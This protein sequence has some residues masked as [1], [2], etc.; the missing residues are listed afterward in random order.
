M[1]DT[2]SPPQFAEGDAAFRARGDKAQA[3]RAYELYKKA[4]TENP[5]DA[6]AGW[7]YAMICYF[8]GIKHT[9]TD[10]QRREIY[11][12]GRD[13][14]LEALK[15]NDQC[16]ACYFWTAIDMA[17]YG[18]ATGPFKMF[19][20]LGTIKEYLEKGLRI[21]PAYA[22]GGAYRLLGQIDE[23]LPGFLGGSVERAALHYEKAIATVPDE[24]MNYLF[25]AKLL[26]ESKKLPEQALGVAKR[27]LGIPAPSTDRLESNEALQDLRELVKKLEAPRK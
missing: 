12:A 18:Q 22:Y 13:A 14:G 17:L 15:H 16:A 4:Y 1:H 23:A 26:A 25:L 10:E 5:T 21:D 6:E 11:S 20:S 9:T 7:R 27:G 19:F 24:P 3:T 8:M 2:K